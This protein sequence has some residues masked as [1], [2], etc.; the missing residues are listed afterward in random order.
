MNRPYGE[1]NPMPK[2]LRTFL[3]D[4]RRAYPSEVV[5]IAK[6][7][8]PL[9]YDVT[10]IVKQLGALKKFPILI[11]EQPLN[12]HGHANDM[13]LV[14]S[15]ENSQKKIQ[16]ALG[17]PTETD[18]AEMARECLRR[19]AAKIGPVIV[20]K[21]SA[22]V[23]EIIQTG[24]LSRSLRAAAVAPSRNGRRALYRYVE[25]CAGPRQRRLQLLVSPDGNQ[26]S[27]PYR[28][29]DDACS[30]CGGF[31]AATKKPMKNVRSP[32]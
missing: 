7:V 5:S 27:K 12:A 31:F 10:A 14:M 3:D 24:D 19:E 32:R 8:N 16:V 15:A 21:D 2:S 4:M 23:K 26:R 18:R 20:R 11:F 28:L 30:I 9:S 13:K 25:R 1:I 6:T 22:P 29:P 17:V